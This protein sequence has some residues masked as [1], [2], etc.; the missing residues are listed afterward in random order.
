MG[1]A[2]I[3]ILIANAHR[4]SV[5]AKFATLAVHGALWLVRESLKSI[6]NGDTVFAPDPST[7]FN[8]SDQ[9]AAVQELRDLTDEQRNDMFVAGFRG[10]A[11]TGPQNQFE[12]L[13][14]RDPAVLQE[15]FA[16]SWNAIANE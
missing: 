14:A 10:M 16:E 1:I 2:P 8:T 12:L 11:H 7:I 4:P 3:N 13:L 9:S 6:A 15:A 5:L